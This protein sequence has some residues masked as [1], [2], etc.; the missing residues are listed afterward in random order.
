MENPEDHVRT[1]QWCSGFSAHCLFV[2]EK[3]QLAMEGE[4]GHPLSRISVA[5]AV[6]HTIVLVT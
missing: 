1:Q 4:I 6:S 5:R 2:K 3:P